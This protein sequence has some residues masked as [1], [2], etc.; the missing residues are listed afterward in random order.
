MP[1]HRVACAVAALVVV[2][3]AAGAGAA[4]ATR[5]R[6]TGPAAV[7]QLNPGDSIQ[8][9]V[10]AS[11]PGTQ[12]VLAPGLYRLQS[13]VPKA[14][15][16]FVGPVSRQ[17]VTAAA[18]RAAE[19]AAAAH[20]YASYLPP[21]LEELDGDAAAAVLSGSWLLTNATR[22]AATGTWRVDGLA[23]LS[24]WQHGSCDA[25]HPAC[26][27]TQELFL[28]G[29]RLLRVAAAGD[30]LPL[31]GTWFLDYGSGSGGSGASS[32]SLQ[33]SEDPTNRTLELSALE[34]AFSGAVSGVT[35]ANLVLD[36][37]ATPAQQGAIV[38]GAAP[39]ATE[40][41]WSVVG[42][43][44]RNAHGRAVDVHYGGVVAGGFLHHNGQLG[45]G[46]SNGSVTGTEVGAR[47]REVATQLS[48]LALRPVHH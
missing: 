42:V 35:I 15:Q 48:Q 41:A 2:A 18:L 8:A 16:S 3:V 23:G 44:V 9:A 13:V 20:D 40:G 22:D 12:F 38:M 5:S 45:F 29:A 32:Q 4:A 31:S 43:E 1:R 33:L 10:D 7:V 14:G 24:S 6:A 37:Y 39:G 28:D 25:A 21:L 47:G 27:Y 17:T 19:A 26:N 46:G 11:A 36:M 30:V 34:V